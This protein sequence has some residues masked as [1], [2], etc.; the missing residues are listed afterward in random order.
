M[1]PEDEDLMLF[2]GLAVTQLDLE[3][4]SVI[5]TTNPDQRIVDIH[6]RRTVVSS[7]EH[8]QE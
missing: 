2:A 1:R 3:T 4:D 7:H 6:G 5:I 8:A